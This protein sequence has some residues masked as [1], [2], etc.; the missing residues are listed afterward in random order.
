MK[1]VV[2]SAN[3]S[4]YL[5]NFRASTIRAF[6]SEGYK[7]VCISPNDEYTKKLTEEL[8][9]DWYNIYID[10]QGSNPLKDVLL[11]YSLFK[12]YRKV[13]PSVVFNFT[14]KNN[15]YG[16]WA[17]YLCRAKVVNNV[18]GLGTAFINNNLTSKLVKLLY[19]LSQPLADRVFCQNPEDRELLTSHKLVNS[20][21]L[22]LLPGSGVNVD[23]F[24]PTLK[25][26][27]DINTPFRFLYVGRMLGDKG[28]IELIEAA[29]KLAK[30]GHCFT[31]DLCGFS[32]VKN[33]SSLSVDTLNSLSV[34]DYLNWLGPSKNM[35]KVYANS[36]C[37]VLPSYREGMPRSLL[38]A[39]AMGL[40]SIATNVP[41]CK[42]IIKHGFNGYLCEVKSS[43]S[44]AEQMLAMLEV[45]ETSYRA[46][47]LNS[48]QR[49]EQ[50]YD[51]KIVIR[52]ALDSVEALTN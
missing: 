50:E 14:I 8:G 41:G 24:K 26:E 35:T 12:I 38:E 3:T 7:V 29:H 33:V 47:C 21:K 44:L 45:D 10:N 13:A 46:M 31:V 22:F 34:F 52:H 37:V 2:L 25:L 17:A 42:H 9:C 19:R 23:I 40:P 16:T 4:F 27:R 48:R 32:G 43:K 39:G 11:C 30:E 1:T 18:S 5:Y 20:D 49:V 15:I 36:D 6:L 51:E 28:V